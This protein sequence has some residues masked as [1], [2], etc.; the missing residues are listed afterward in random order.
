[1][2]K[3]K[4]MRYKGDNQGWKKGELG[5]YIK[6]SG[7]KPGDGWGNQADIGTSPKGH[8]KYTNDDVSFLTG[9]A[10]DTPRTDAR[11]N[12]RE[13]WAEVEAQQSDDGN[14]A[15]KSRGGQT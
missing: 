3:L 8:G 14:R 11:L 15:V 5:K 1:M 12:E 6:P 13:I 9:K 10:S 7:V 2:R 4:N